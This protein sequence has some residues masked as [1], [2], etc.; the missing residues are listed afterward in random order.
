MKLIPALEYES[1]REENA[2]N[3]IYVHKDG[4]FYHIYEWSAW[5]VKTF[6]CTEDFQRERGD[7]SILQALRYKAKGKDY[8]VLGFPLESLSKYIPEYGTVEQL[9]GD[10]LKICIN[11]ADDVDYEEMTNNFEEWKASCP[12]KETKKKGRRDVVY[13]DG[14]A[15]MLARSG[16]FQIVSKI[17]SYPLESSTPTQNIEFLGKLRQEVAALL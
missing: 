4:K 17:L 9:E 12:A 11:L 10:D 6:V 1:L 8:V 14:T 7:E 15:P 16:L 3:E 2:K 5:L 13:G